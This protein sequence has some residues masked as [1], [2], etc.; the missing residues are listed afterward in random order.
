M[1]ENTPPDTAWRPPADLAQG[2]LAMAV[3]VLLRAAPRT[4]WP[5]LAG[6]GA[7]SLGLELVAKQMGIQLDGPQFTASAWVYLAALAVV[8]SALT[9]AM[10]HILLTGR[11][12][13]GLDAG[14]VGFVIWTAVVTLLAQGMMSVILGAPKAP[15]AELLPRFALVAIGGVGGAI[16]LTR[17]MLLPMAWLVGDPGATAA[18]SWGRMRGQLIGYIVAS[19]LLSLPV[20]MVGVLAIGAA[21]GSE[22]EMTAGA[23]IAAQVM[24]MAMAA[25][26]VGL[27]AVMYLRLVGAPQRLGEVFE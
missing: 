12:P 14:F 8:T 25:L 16:V 10:L 2:P 21:G 15:P 1:S 13:S 19:L 23:R 5:V 24:A 7:V 11:G 20:V 9:G 17:L 6:L 26:S 27:N 3:L 18:G 4:I 22:G